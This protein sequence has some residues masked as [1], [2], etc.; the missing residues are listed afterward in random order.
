MNKRKTLKI[1]KKYKT[2]IKSKYKKRKNTKKKVNKNQYGGIHKTFPTEELCKFKDNICN[3]AGDCFSQCIRTL[4][5]VDEYYNKI[6]KGKIRD[7]GKY[8]GEEQE[9]IFGLEI[10][11]SRKSMSEKIKISKKFNITDEH[12]LLDEL[13]KHYSGIKPGYMKFLIINKSFNDGTFKFHCVLIARDIQNNLYLIDPKWKVISVNKD[14]YYNPWQGYEFKEQKKAITRDRYIF[15]QT[16]SC[17]WSN[18]DFY[19]DVHLYF[20]TLNNKDN[21]DDM[22]PYQVQVEDA[23]IISYMLRE[24]DQTPNNVITEYYDDDWLHNGTDRNIWNKRPSKKFLV[25][26]D[27]LIGKYNEKIIP[28]EL[29]QIREQITSLKAELGIDT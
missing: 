25:D 18:P 21:N 6:M 13:I 5:N 29:K 8:I 15:N 27:E 7:L 9:K 11:K 19:N 10:R 16:D 1:P 17:E 28:L 22:N 14:I 12:K 23:S 24:G 20:E 3:R 2:K 26:K 4:T